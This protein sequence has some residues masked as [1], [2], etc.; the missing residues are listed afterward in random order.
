MQAPNLQDD[1]RKQD[2]QNSA[3]DDYERKFNGSLGQDDVTKGIQDLEN[4]A[5]KKD[6]K[7]LEA[8]K[9]PIEEQEDKAD[10]INGTNGEQPQTVRG[11]LLAKGLSVAKK[12]GGLIGL[13]AALGVGGGLLAGIFGPASMVINI[14]EN[15][16]ATN[17]SMSV[18]LE[19]RVMKVLGY[20]TSESDAI[21]DN[22]TKLTLTC[23][24]G[25][26]SSSALK[27][28]EKKGVKAF[29]ANGNAVDTTKKYPDRNP[30]AY[31]FDLGDGSD[32]VRV[33]APEMT[34]FLSE[35]PRH[36]V[37]VLGIGGAFNVTARAW[38]GNHITKRFFDPFG[39]SKKGGFLD[40]VTKFS[41][42]SDERMKQML[43]RLRAKIPGAEAANKAADKVRS[44]VQGHLG[45]AQKGGVGYM[46]AVSGCVATKA[47]IIFAGAAAG[48]Q[49]L[50]YVG[51]V[52]D[53]V[54]SPGSKLK[55][56]GIEG[57]SAATPEAVGAVNTLLTTQALDKPSG[58][59]LSMTDAPALQASIG[60]NTNKITIPKDTPGFSV[61]NSDIVVGSRK[62][63]K[64]AE[65]ACNAI[66]SPAAMWSAF[67]VDS[68][69]TVAAS[70]TVVLGVVKVLVSLAASAVI[71][72]VAGMVVETLAKEALVALME[73]KDLANA[74]GK[75]L[76]D[77]VGIGAMAYFSSAAMSRYVPGLKM[78]Q[79]RGFSALKTETENFEKQMAVASLS[80]FDTSS[81]Y[82]FL[83]SIVH[84][85][86]TAIVV[87]GGYNGNIISTIASIAS[88]PSTFLNPTVGAS[89]N[90][91]ENYCGYAKD[92]GLEIVDANGQPDPDNTPAINAAGLP[93]TGLTDQQASMST[94]QAIDLMA[95]EGWID[96]SKPI[97]DGDTIDDLMSS[98]VIVKDTP[99]TDFI[100]SCGS[101]ES[102]DYLFN[103]AGCTTDGTVKD[104]TKVQDSFTDEYK[105][106]ENEDGETVC[107][108]DLAELDE[109]ADAGVDNA[110]SLTARSVFLLDYQLNASVNGQDEI[111][112]SSTSTSEATGE[113]VLPVDPGYTPFSSGQDWGPRNIC[114]SSDTNSY[115]YF[116]RGADFAYGGSTSGKPVYSVTNGEVIEVGLFN[117]ACSVS[118]SGAGKWDNRVMV[119]H[120]DGTISG[121]SHMT[122]DSIVAAGIKVGDKVKAGQ[123]IGAIGKCGNTQG[124]HLHFTISPGE[125]TR[126]D[127]LSWETN[128]RGDTYVDPI[129]YMALYGVDL[130]NGV[131]TDGR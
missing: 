64:T 96:E 14:M 110:E 26:I 89:A 98:G 59:M 104:A 105:C 35:N 80:P 51:Y 53:I 29:D 117:T 19:Q 50:P 108:D 131:Y 88:V 84:N 3:Q 25:S 46:L 65:P 39:L 18:S 91:T 23:K 69:V 74:Q 56:S 81:K 40:G 83:G 92:F 97:N 32:K 45:K 30:A 38:T 68:A 120:E 24:M 99:L 52:N 112:F 111:D 100:E 90:F 63:N 118:T 33:P 106:A 60:V 4:F 12:R 123:Q 82:T 58:K 55:A 48:V 71:S 76:G 11:K 113:Y 31:E 127:V 93:C 125:T 114:S 115:C 128:T 37:R 109:S 27:Q 36:A 95:K 86:N 122:V 103:A 72:H 121:Y 16:T 6:E 70:S 78:S 13:L 101:P 22:N 130:T 102:G 66:M 10:W 42:N 79:L 73:N 5:N 15:M 129:A 124:A 107:M 116:H 17:D 28:L 126:P 75:A 61:L 9:K 94:P 119:K 7:Q 43:D 21:C 77:I 49:L 2:S 1:K 57:S 62:F 44:K 20:S 34:K 85:I 41:S 67:A 54:L 87:N 47:P 8:T